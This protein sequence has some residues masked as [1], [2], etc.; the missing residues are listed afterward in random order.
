ML[1]KVN[2]VNLLYDFYGQMLTK[3]QRE[4]LELYYR[5]DLSFGEIASEHNVSRQAI[6]DL[7]NRAVNLLE[8][9]ESR[10][11]FYSH[12]SYQQRKLKEVD[13]ILQKKI[14]SP[15]EH[16]HLKVIIAE[17]IDDHFPEENKECS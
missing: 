3:R 9:L 2:R 10:L 16:S 12:F 1:E 7:I 13:K 8:K 17:I 15:E 4:L 5:H 11:K 14:I 6:Y